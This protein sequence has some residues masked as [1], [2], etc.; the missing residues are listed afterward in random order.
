MQRFPPVWWRPEV[1]LWGMWSV[2]C[3]IY[4]NHTTCLWKNKVYVT[5][6]LHPSWT[7]CVWPFVQKSK[8][9]LVRIWVWNQLIIF[10]CGLF[11]YVLSVLDL[12]KKQQQSK[13]N[14]FYFWHLIFAFSVDCRWVDLPLRCYK[15]LFTLKFQLKRVMTP[16]T[17]R[18]I[19]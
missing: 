2:S 12:I 3:L 5:Q 4:Q 17:L 15:K 19:V 1:F 6:H 8:S 18:P 7:G 9:P 14:Y 13:L 11:Y 10:F 16:T